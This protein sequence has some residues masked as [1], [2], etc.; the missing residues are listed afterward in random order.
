MPDYASKG[1]FGNITLQEHGQ[2]EGLINSNGTKATNFS[3]GFPNFTPAS[4][5][6]LL[7][8]VERQCQDFFTSQADCFIVLYSIDD[9]CSSTCD[10]DTHGAESIS[11]ITPLIQ[12][13]CSLQTPCLTNGE[14][15][16][17]ECSN[18]LTCSSKRVEDF[19][20]L[21]AV[22]WK[23]QM[24]RGSFG[25]PLGPISPP[26]WFCLN[27][28]LIW[29]LLNRGDLYNNSASIDGEVAFV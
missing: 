1:K 3:C 16:F 12:L 2:I 17:C 6:W 24:Q 9:Y 21:A 11:R 13:M 10:I 5:Q 15:C 18:Q 19:G 14:S 20:L 28:L 4:E 25:A 22:M 29:L 23:A 8:F 26:L 27:K 7:C